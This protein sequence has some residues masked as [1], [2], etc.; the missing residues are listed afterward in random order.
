VCFHVEAVLGENTK[1]VCGI[2][3]QR[4]GALWIVQE[5]SEDFWSFPEAEGTKSN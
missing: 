2:P 1:N 4:Q 5:D 3:G